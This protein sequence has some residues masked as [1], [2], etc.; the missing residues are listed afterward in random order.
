MPS[1]IQVSFVIIQLTHFLHF[2]FIYAN[3]LL[4]VCAV[5]RPGYFYPRRRVAIGAVNR[6]VS[7]SSLVCAYSARSATNNVL[8]LDHSQFL[9]DPLNPILR[10]FGTSQS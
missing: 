8:L 5:S 10:Y 9:H 3:V 6:L 2:R 1:L 4:F 7:A